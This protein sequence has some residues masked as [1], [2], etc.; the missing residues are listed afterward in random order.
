MLSISAMCSYGC[1]LSATVQKPSASGYAH[2]CSSDASL[3]LAERG[4]CLFF[5]CVAPSMLERVG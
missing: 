2:C 4:A 5:V 1:H 3:V